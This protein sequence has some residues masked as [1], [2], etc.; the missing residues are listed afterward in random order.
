MSV[1]KNEFDDQMGRGTSSPG[2]LQPSVLGAMWWGIRRAWQN[3]AVIF[4][5]WLI[6]LSVALFLVAPLYAMIYDHTALSTSAEQLGSGF[7]A[8][9]WTD[10]SFA[11]G[12]ALAAWQ[13]SLWVAGAFYLVLHVFLAGGVL[14]FLYSDQRFPFWARFGSSC[15]T[16]FGRFFRLVLI[17]LVFY[18]VVFWIDGLL[19][20]MVDRLSDNGGLQPQAWWGHLI[21]SVVIVALFFSV[22]LL[23]DYAKVRTV[24][25]DSRSMIIE[26]ARTLGFVLRNAPRVATLYLLLV[27][28]GAALMAAYWGSS[29]VIEGTGA[30]LLALFV[31]QQTYVAARIWLRL[32]T[33]GGAMSLYRGLTARRLAARAAA[34]R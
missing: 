1:E 19:F 18:G 17:S 24:V 9:W 3:K 16:Y 31:A 23:F 26:T 28:L 21:R 11:E 27:S 15:G 5:L 7:T 30:G 14:A 6:N 2:A 13:G 29:G 12:A 25:R 10:F 34:T 33:W 4:W 32:A 22:S 20:E 8:T